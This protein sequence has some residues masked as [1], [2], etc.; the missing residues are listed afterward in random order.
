MGDHLIR[1]LLPGG[2]ARVVAALTTE[3]SAEAARRHGASPD[4]TAALARGVTAGLLLAT[5][6]KGGERVSL[7]LR[8]DGPLGGLVVD[9]NDAGDVRA[10]LQRPA[11]TGGIG[12]VGRVQVSRDLGLKESYDGQAVLVAGTIDEDVEHYLRTSEQIESALGCELAGG[13][14]GGVLVQCLPGGRGDP[15]VAAARQ[16]LRDETLREALVGEV[17]VLDRRPLRFHCPCSRER[18][19]GALALLGA[20]ELISMIDEDGAAEVTCHFCGERYELGRPELERILTS[21][22]AEKT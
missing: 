16:R 8:G 13:R 5:L 19:T 14:A 11:A 15:L 6:T 2:R 4:G 18:V 7:R 9:A 1:G 22:P 17:D 3:T 20:G 21:L 10:F 12:R